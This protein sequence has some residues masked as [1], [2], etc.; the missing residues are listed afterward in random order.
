MVKMSISASRPLNWNV[1]GATKE[2]MHLRQLTA[3]DRAAEQ[4]G[5]V[6]ALTMPEIA[7]PRLSLLTGFV[8]DALPGWRDVTTLPVAE[9]IRALGDPDVR[10]RLRQ[11]GESP[12]AGA[13]ARLAANWREMEVAETVSSENRGLEGRKIGDV[14]D[15]RGERAVRHLP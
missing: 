13:I 14:A 15:E 7:R 1:L 6:V 5:R 12:E 4:G 10:L 11:G 2:G 8:F 3:S 9:R